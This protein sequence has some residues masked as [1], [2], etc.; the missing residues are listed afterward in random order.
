MYGS[1]ASA[2][3]IE[4]TAEQAKLA[5]AEKIASVVDGLEEDE[6]D[7]LA[8]A[9]DILDSNG[10]EFETAEEKLAAAAEVVDGV[11]DG[12]IEIEEAKDD[13]EKIAAE[14]DAAGRIMARAFAN[15]LNLDEED[16]EALVLK[17]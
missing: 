13:S 7:K 12:S 15:E 17:R 9:C 16:S 3:N 5:E 2:G 6:C 8:E 14:Y 4:K 11:E 1:E 10:Y